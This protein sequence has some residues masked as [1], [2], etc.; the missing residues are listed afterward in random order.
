MTPRASA[1]RSV[2]VGGDQDGIQQALDLGADGV[3]VP[4]INTA[5]EARAAVSHATYPTQGT[6]S[7]YFPQRSM[8]KKVLPSC[9]A[10]G[11]EGSH[12]VWCGV[13]LR[14]GSAG[15]R[16]RLEQECH[17]RPARSDMPHRNLR[18]WPAYLAGWHS[19]VSWAVCIWLSFFKRFKGPLL[20]LC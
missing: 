15:L 6:R 20:G 4:Y 7:V 16:R 17:R 2:G 12:K 8:N 9:S 18:T 14:A 19:P 10:Y 3:I 5:D 13:P 1:F 11:G